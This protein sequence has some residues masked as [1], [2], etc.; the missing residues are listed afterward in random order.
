MTG[1][2]LVSPQITQPKCKPNN[3]SFLIEIPHGVHF[4]PL[5]ATRNTSN[6]FNYWFVPGGL[7]PEGTER[8]EAVQDW[9]QGGDLC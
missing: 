1:Y 6:L 2:A 9:V 4:F 7:W 3:K 8:Q 5:L